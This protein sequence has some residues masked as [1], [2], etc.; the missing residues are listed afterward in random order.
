MLR[1]LLYLALL[2]L[3]LV[4]FGISLIILRPLHQSIVLY[5]VFV[6]MWLAASIAKVYSSLH[7]NVAIPISP[8]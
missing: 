5:V 3:A 1:F 8:F 7:M 4:V 2:A 6:P